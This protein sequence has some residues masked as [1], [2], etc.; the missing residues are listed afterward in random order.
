MYKKNIAINFLASGIVFIVNF[1]INFFL[2]P[3]IVKTIGE[4]AYGFYNLGMQFISYATII[5]LALNS[6]AGKFVTI[7]LQKDE[8]EA[9]RYFC[10][11]FYGNIVISAILFVASFFIIVNIQRFLHISNELVQ[12]VKLLWGFLFASFL[13]GLVFNVYSIATFAKNQL[14]LNSL[15]TIIQNIIKAGILLILYSC[16]APAIWYLGFSAFVCSVFAAI[17]GVIITRKLLPD[18]KIQ[19]KYFHGRS[20]RKLIAAGSWNSLT[21]FAGVLNNGLDLLLSNLYISPAAM[22]IMAIAKTIPTY[23]SQFA[24]TFVTAFIPQI[25]ISYATDDFDGMLNNINFCHKIMTLVLCIPTAMIAVFGKEFFAL[26]MPTINSYSVQLISLISL[27]VYFILGPICALNEVI[28]ITNKHKMIAITYTISG[29]I[30]II[31]VACLLRFISYKGY[32]SIWGVDIEIIKLMIVAGIS[33]IIGIIR[34]LLFTPVYAA[35]CIGQKWYCFYP[36]ILKG[37]VSIV[38]C[39][40]FSMCIRLLG[41]TNTWIELFMSFAISLVGMC[42][43]CITILFNEDER[44]M[45]KNMIR[46]K[47]FNRQK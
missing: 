18:F 26:W 34:N 37:I 41:I 24:S 47:L 43:I 15:S 45:I 46:D 2:S 21:Q 13:V 30:N 9:R 36:M 29:V 25:T 1:A 8:T 14:Y 44:K 40:V 10:S 17:F 6:M 16:F 12:D 22:G 3:F 35:Y 20:I 27:A 19:K 28:T 38:L 5:T 4:E 32:E 39:C 11:A 42:M 33:S 7:S 23:L 31:V